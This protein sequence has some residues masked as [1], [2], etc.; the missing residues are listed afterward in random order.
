VR[1]DIDPDGKG[2]TKVWANYEVA[3]TV[4]GKL[5]TRNGLLYLY[6][7]KMENNVDVYYFTAM[8]FR[9]GQVVWEKKVGSGFRFDHYYEALLLGP[10]ATI[11]MGV[12]DGLVT[13]RD[14]R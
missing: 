5:S 9:T 3:S 7:R 1:I 10:D 2:C 8:D 12:Y 13:I 6:T 14:S 11:F 4:S